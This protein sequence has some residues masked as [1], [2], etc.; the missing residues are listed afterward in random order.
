MGEENRVATRTGSDML[1]SARPLGPAAAPLST[2][3][4]LAS[5]ASEASLERSERRKALKLWGMIDLPKTLPTGVGEGKSNRHGAARRQRQFTA[6]ESE[7]DKVFRNSNS[8]PAGK[9]FSGGPPDPPSAMPPTAVDARR[10]V[11]QRRGTDRL[12]AAGGCCSQQ[13]VRKSTN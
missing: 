4:R 6:P 1:P 13:D 2:R 5:G 10:A 9:S 3:A 11:V 8:S 12:P 7:V